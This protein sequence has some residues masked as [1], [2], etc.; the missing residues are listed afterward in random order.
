VDNGEFI[1]FYKEFGIAHQ[2]EECLFGL[3]W[4]LMVFFLWVISMVLLLTAVSNIWD[5]LKQYRIVK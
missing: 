4:I 5:K 2:M 1:V 3:Q